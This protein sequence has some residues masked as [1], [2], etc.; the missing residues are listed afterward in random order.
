MLNISNYEITLHNRV[1]SSE[2][3]LA[4]RT[5]NGSARELRR[6]FS[7]TS[8]FEDTKVRNKIKQEI[9][10]DIEFINS[11]DENKNDIKNLSDTQKDT[12]YA[13]S[14]LKNE[15]MAL[16]LLELIMFGKITTLNQPVT[17]N[18]NSS[19]EYSMKLTIVFLSAF[20]QSFLNK[21][22]SAM[23]HVNRKID[24][25]WFQN[26][27]KIKLSNTAQIF[28]NTYILPLH[29]QKNDGTTLSRK[30][31][32]YLD[33]RLQHALEKGTTIKKAINSIETIPSS[34]KFEVT[35]GGLCRS[36]QKFGAVEDRKM[37]SIANVYEKY[38]KECTENGYNLLKNKASE[39][40]SKNKNITNEIEK[41]NGSIATYTN[42]L[43]AITKKQQELQDRI[44]TD[45]F[46]GD[47][48]GE[49][50]KA[51]GY[52]SV[53]NEIQKNP[54]VPDIQSLEDLHVKVV[55]DLGYLNL[56][57]TNCK[58]IQK[59]I[60]K[61][62]E[63]LE[64]EF[65]Q[66][67][68]TQDNDKQT[69]WDNI[70]GGGESDVNIVML[71]KPF[72]EELNTFLDSDA[73]KQGI[74]DHIYDVGNYIWSNIKSGFKKLC[75]TLGGGVIGG[76]VGVI[77]NNKL[78]GI[79]GAI[80]GG[81]LGFAVAEARK[82]NHVTVAIKNNNQIVSNHEKQLL[83]SAYITKIREFKEMVEK[84]EDEV[85]EGVEKDSESYESNLE[86]Y[87]KIINVDY[88]KIKTDFLKAFMSNVHNEI[89]NPYISH[90]FKA[91]QQLDLINNF[92]KILLGNYKNKTLDVFDKDMKYLQTKFEDNSNDKKLFIALCE[93]F[94]KYLV[95]SAEQHQRKLLN[96]M[97]LVLS[98]D[99]Q[100]SNCIQGYSTNRKALVKNI[101][102]LLLNTGILLRLY[103]KLP[104]GDS[105]T[106]DMHEL[107]EKQQQLIEQRDKLKKE[108]NDIE[109]SILK[110]QDEI[111]SKAKVL[112]ESP[113]FDKIECSHAQIEEGSID[114]QIKILKKDLQKQEQTLI[115][116]TKTSADYYNK[117]I[118]KFKEALSFR[119]LEKNAN[120]LEQSISLISKAFNDTNECMVKDLTILIF[121]RVNTLYR[122]QFD[123]SNSNKAQVITW[124]D[125]DYITSQI[126]YNYEL[127]KDVTKKLSDACTQANAVLYAYFYISK[128]TNIQTINKYLSEND[129]KHDDVELIKNLE[130][131]YKAYESGISDKIKSI[132][133]KVHTNVSGLF[134]T[135]TFYKPNDIFVD[136]GV[137]RN[138]G[139][140]QSSLGK[141]DGFIS[142]ESNRIQPSLITNNNSQIESSSENG[143]DE[144]ED[145][146]LQPSP[147]SEALQS[148]NENDSDNIT[149][150]V[151]LENP[152]SIFNSWQ[153]KIKN[154]IN[155][156]CSNVSG[157][158]SPA[159]FA[160]ILRFLAVYCKH[161]KIKVKGD[162]L[163]L[164]SEY[165]QAWQREMYLNSGKNT[166]G[167]L[168]V[169]INSNEAIDTR[170][171]YEICKDFLDNSLIQNNN[172][173]F[174]KN[175][176][177]PSTPS[178]LCD[179]IDL[180][181]E[182]ITKMA[183][184]VEFFCSALNSIL[185]KKTKDN[186]MLSLNRLQ[187]FLEKCLYL[188]TIYSDYKFEI[189]HAGTNIINDVKQTMQNIGSIIGMD[190]KTS[191]DIGDI[192]I[193]Q[194]SLKLFFVV[195]LQFLDKFNSGQKTSPEIVIYKVLK[196]FFEQLSKQ[197][198]DTY[199]L[200]GRIEYAQNTKMIKLVN[201]SIFGQ[202]SKMV[203]NYEAL[204]QYKFDS[205]NSQSEKLSITLDVAKIKQNIL[206]IKSKNGLIEL[207][208]QLHKEYLANILY[209]ESTDEQDC[210]SQDIVT[211]NDT[212]KLAIVLA[213]IIKLSSNNDGYTYDKVKAT[214]NNIFEP[215]ISKDETKPNNIGQF[216]G[217][218]ITTPLWFTLYAM[219]DNI[220]NHDANS[221]D[222][223]MGISGFGINEI[224]DNPNYLEYMSLT[225]EHRNLNHLVSNVELLLVKDKPRDL[226]KNQYYDT[227]LSYFNKK[228]SKCI[229]MLHALINVLSFRISKKE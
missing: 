80:L 115:A 150:T 190:N 58:N 107:I 228:D 173:T 93:Y 11:W 36:A 229:F 123:E 84:K 18:E 46:I 50:L 39:L 222:K 92:Y 2:A 125:V 154:N 27:N 122:S 124:I 170:S 217:R 40:K 215:F 151:A 9:Q 73:F 145:K 101:A 28:I 142:L 13:L 71:M 87:N 91:I 138:Q 146:I 178:R 41:I 164:E 26:K 120:I 29:Q 95:M 75:F 83:A 152:D 20:P 158:L 171:S 165:S 192:T 153:Q 210:V 179:T 133:A 118:A 99:N 109:E 221:V 166:D 3:N 66:I 44:Q 126:Q 24:S 106:T 38:D 219:I 187:I 160:N 63:T 167:L 119:Y 200:T 175:D 104:K 19:L 74:R 85:K 195:Y 206:S 149:C 136:T 15:G 7:I 62:L 132:K 59:N 88:E 137:Q 148:N 8:D 135:S 32:S 113:K 202:T 176:N 105:P 57:L 112:N 33:N 16:K 205:K 157:R 108:F 197:I 141:N 77:A 34:D 213:L 49:L 68:G 31:S 55:E 216:W 54:K 47:N 78:V 4:S 103:G 155:I 196:Q 117:I 223:S 22:L 204:K 147:K 72:S 42:L 198:Q 220:L 1:F 37:T 23:S 90:D 30:F 193:F 25:T 209:I 218:N 211:F 102:T 76:S 35:S 226:D 156:D 162:F 81:G 225:P 64:T 96:D 86:G 69:P 214:L 174:I 131:L 12:A 139:V 5:A 52:E 191:L 194:R 199:V 110:L 189:V 56:S 14:L 127:D 97:W 111:T 79:G 144:Y 224:K 6:L 161:H 227:R 188:M 208:N 17:S 180:T 116:L 140:V 203:M 212:L 121:D 130:N 100:Q 82:K 10:K 129:I 143:Y 60:S 53:W 183:M 168:R 128:S 70:L 185:I 43:K 172:I 163:K 184:E 201:S 61:N 134:N 65:T 177:I 207:I 114:E 98:N 48:E 67:V 159:V 181:S 21:I 45:I 51:I 186:N 94:S 89:N 182:V 169:S